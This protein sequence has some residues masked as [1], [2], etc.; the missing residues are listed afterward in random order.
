MSFKPVPPRWCRDH[1]IHW[2]ALKMA[3][4]IIINWKPFYT[5]SL[6]NMLLQSKL[7]RT[8]VQ[9]PKICSEERYATDFSAMWHESEPSLN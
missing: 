8:Q 9:T 5:D 2:R 7:Q 3:Y 6:K 1:Y 4:N